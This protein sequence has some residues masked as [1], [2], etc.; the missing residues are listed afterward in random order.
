MT[1]NGSSSAGSP[2]GATAT[3]TLG[4]GGGGIAFIPASA[5]LIGL[6][7]YDGRFLRADDLNLERQGQRAYAEYSN[8]AGGPGVVYG[9]DLTRQGTRL[10]LSAGLAVDPKGRLLYLPDAV[11]AEIADLIQASQPPASA[12]APGTAASPAGFGPCEQASTATVTTAVGGSE[13][14]LACVSQAQGLCGQGE[15]FGRACDTACVAAT[16]RPYLVDGVALSL[17]PLKLQHPL[18]TLAGLTRPDVHLRS[19]VASAF[20]ADERDQGGSLLSAGGLRAPVWCAGATP[21]SAGDCVPVG[22]LGWDGSAVTFLDAWIARRERIEAPPRGYW[23]GRMELRPWPVFLAQVLQFQCQLADL[24]VTLPGP[25]AP[26][27]AWTRILLQAGVVT[28]PPGGFLAVDPGSGIA[29]R[30]QLQALLGDGVELRFCAVRRDQIAHELERAQHMDRISLIQGLRNQAD[31][32]QVDILVP[33]GVLE[34]DTAPRT[35][36]GFAV[37]L[38]VGPGVRGGLAGVPAAA[39][40]QLK[41]HGVGRVSLDNGI[42]VRAAVAGSAQEAVADMARLITG[43]TGS[44]PGWEQTLGDLHALQ[45]GPGVGS[46][47]LLRAVANAVVNRAIAQRTAGER[48]GVIDVAAANGEVA[49][50]SVSSWL[51]QDPFAMPDG[52]IMSAPFHLGLDLMVPA[53]QTVSVKFIADG[54]LK[55]VS[56]RTGTTGPV[57]R[58]S[59]T[60]F[61]QSAITGGREDTSGGSFDHTL[62]LRRVQRHGRTMLALTDDRP[63][64]MIGVGWQG[65]PVQASGALVQIAVKRLHPMTDEEIADVL[66]QILGGPKGQPLPPSSSTGVV[67]SFEA[68]EDAAISQPGDPHRESAI[69]ALQILSGLYPE[70]PGY[71]ERGYG[72]LF[73]PA[74]AA[75][76]RVRPTTDWV[77]FRRRRR[78]D[79]EG[80]AG[81]ALPG[82]SKVA[83]WVTRAESIDQAKSMAD[84]LFGGAGA[85]I[86][87]KA[88]Q[89][90]FL[91]FEEGAATL[92]TTPAAWRTRYQTVGGGSMVFGAG[93]ASG[94]GGSD[95]PVGIG[96][97]RALVDACAPVATFDPQ[98]RVDLVTTPPAD[99]M[100]AGTEGSIFLISYQPDS[101]EVITVDAADPHNRELVAAIRA[102]DA[103]TVAAAPAP[104]VPV[105]DVVDVTSRAEDWAGRLN[106]ELTGRKAELDLAHGLD[107]AWDPVV[108]MHRDLAGE[109]E[110]QSEDHVN[111]ILAALGVADV[112]AVQR[113]AVGF[114]LGDRPPVRIYLLFEIPQ[115]G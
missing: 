84:A 96:R 20:F 44:G 22:V 67:A 15:V 12:T 23:S 55:R 36:R 8:Q 95:A 30:P 104:A 31:R 17:R 73:P 62:V 13:L 114:E 97:A 46:T 27:S 90:D 99:E 39:S 5:P 91:E 53:E 100:L 19:Q 94:P 38:A 78:E 63:T 79:C 68:A 29:L 33:D 93:Y 37:D 11:G 111:Q 59:V 25:G 89:G 61:Y 14:Y 77:L 98:G 110:K 103:D 24:G 3:V 75:Q 60:G 51:A 57:V 92:L 32:E 101:V 28:V 65:D 4:N 112:Q 86:P 2:I 70:D 81:P 72:E 105:L 83:A 42:T 1:V 113:H 85:D 34:T 49:A 21:P 87:W 40:N 56:G 50:L 45:F 9:F 82:R 16:D 7:Y 88:A 35:D 6:N 54:G 108:W 64:W 102:P 48:G 41:M 106:G 115:I 76:T 47:L 10:S 26:A 58:I 107:L 52:T 43:L 109:R 18:P 71:V 69:T 66:E 74:A 80:I